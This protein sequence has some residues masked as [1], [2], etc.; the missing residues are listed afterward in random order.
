MNKPAEDVSQT[1]WTTDEWL[2]HQP[3]PRP[4]VEHAADCKLHGHNLRFLVPT[5]CGGVYRCAKCG[6]YVGWCCGC[7]LGDGKDDLC[8]ECW[9]RSEPAHPAEETDD[10]H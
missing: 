5:G 4:A 1:E 2:A 10:E 8:D 9:A 6:R 7:V 3:G